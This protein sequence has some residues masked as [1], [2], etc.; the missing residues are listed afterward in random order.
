MDPGQSDADIRAHARV[1]NNIARLKDSGAHRFPFT[2]LDANRAWLKVVTIA[3]ALVRWFQLLCLA[4]TR[5]HKAST[6][7]T[8]LVPLAEHPRPPSLVSFHVPGQIRHRP[9]HPTSWPVHPF[10]PSTSGPTPTKRLSTTPGMGTNT[11]QR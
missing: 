10:T 7:N 4:G 2:N 6:Q 3:D 5:L 9:S 11:S 8:A 1:E